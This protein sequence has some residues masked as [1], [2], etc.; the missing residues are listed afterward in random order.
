MAIDSGLSITARPASQPYDRG[1]SETPQNYSTQNLRPTLWDVDTSPNRLLYGDNLRI[2]EKM[3]A[4]SV[5]LI[6]LDPPF[7]SQQTYNLLYRTLTGRP[8]PEQEHAFFDTWTMTQ[9]QWAMLDEMPILVSRY[10]I[11]S[12]YGELW[13][14]WLYALKDSQPKLL[15]YLLYMLRRLMQMH[16]LLKPTG[17]IFLHCDPTASHYLKVLLDGIFGHDNFRNEIIWRR[18]GSHNSA[19]RF[20]P[21][22]DTILF[23][24]KS[25]KYTWNDLKRPYMQGHVDKAFVKK[26]DKYYTN[27]SGNVLSGSGQRGGESGKPW[28][29]FDP[30]SKG[31]HW[32]IPKKITTGLP[33]EFHSMGVH[34]R[35]DYL[36]EHGRI[37][38][39]EGDEWPRYQHEI[40]PTEDGQSVSDLWAY[41]PYTEGTVFGTDA[42]ID[43][44]VRWMGTQDGERLG[45]ETQKPVSLLRRIINATTNPGDVVFDPFCGCGTTVYAAHT[46]DRKWIGCDIAI[47][48]VELVGGTLFQRYGLKPEQ[49]FHITGIPISVKQAEAL[50]NEDAQEFQAWAVQRVDGF[51]IGRKSN[52]RGIDGLLYYEAKPSMRSMVLQVKGGKSIAPTDIRDLRG[53]LEREKNSDLAGFI[54]LREPSKEMKREAVEAGVFMHNDV[55]YPRIQLLTVREILEE[56]R[57]FMTPTKI[58]ARSNTGQVALPIG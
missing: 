55:K 3:K 53:V 6:Y 21:I 47:L 39:K 19:R 35:L 9:D 29:G 20:G 7:N 57:Q 46:T 4:N 49:D 36:Y 42:G 22:H 1:V 24:S 26:F 23:Y 30:D 54:S 11:E 25:D 48:A 31:R 2:M 28:K 43:D 41:Q 13:K 52:D 50:F 58:G 8:V 34:Q 10:G 38:I 5:D 17:S 44:D 33:K 56:K 12:R 14:T 40:S 15:S 16:V 32:A 18:T 51:A 45:Y 37:T 27:Y